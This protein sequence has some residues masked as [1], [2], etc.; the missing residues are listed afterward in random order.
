MEFD[1][2]I[3]GLQL[4]TFLLGLVLSAK[5]FLPYL[6]GWMEKRRQYIEEQITS[7]ET[8]QK[9][10]ER[11]RLELD[12]KIKELDRKTSTII[13]AARNEAETIKEEIVQSSRREGSRILAEARLALQSEQE[14]LKQSLREE[15]VQLSVTMAQ[16]I[17][18]GSVDPKVQ[19][20]VVDE[21]IGELGPDKG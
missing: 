14:E 13:R 1:L 19:A 11:L 17:M 8:S 7:A 4:V 15:V 16:K 2:K 12:Q 10:A 9:E 20:R 5:L 3:F 18:R 21:S 6:R